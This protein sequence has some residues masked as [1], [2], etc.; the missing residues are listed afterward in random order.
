MKKNLNSFTE[1]LKAKLGE[2]LLLVSLYG[3]EARGEHVK[4]H[5]DINVLIILNKRDLS[6]LKSIAGI[7][8]KPAFRDIAPLVFTK[9]YLNSSLD[10]FPIEF[11]DIKENHSVLSGEDCLKGLNIGLKNLRHQCEWELKSK[12]IQLQK[13]YINSGG[14]TKALQQF[15]LKGLPSFVVVFK[16]ILRLK[17]ITVKETD[18]T[19]KRI[20]HEFDLDKDILNELWQARTAN[21]KIKDIQGAFEK[22]LSL[23]YGLSDAVDRL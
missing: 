12:I 3:S 2:N 4:K 19:L 10:T 21:L 5:S 16:N 7:K 13:F 18:E 11:L 1:Q 20:A 6:G 8:K 17:N 9:D 15:L 23:A 22:F 14:K